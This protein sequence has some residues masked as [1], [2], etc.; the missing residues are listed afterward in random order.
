MPHEDFIGSHASEFGQEFHGRRGLLDGV[1]G[2][3][4]LNKKQGFVGVTNGAKTRQCREHSFGFVEH[5]EG[6]IP[7]ST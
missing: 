4:H 2:F 5:G 7:F 3:S 6:T 1:V